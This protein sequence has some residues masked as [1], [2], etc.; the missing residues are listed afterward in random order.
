MRVICNTQS[1]FQKVYVRR[2]GSN[3]RI[4]KFFFRLMFNGEDVTAR[5]KFCAN[6][7]IIVLSEGTLCTFESL[8][9]FLHDDYFSIF[10]SVNFKEACTNA[11]N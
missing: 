4:K 11:R 10:N 2:E 9:R 1:L 3:I 8:I 6:S 7:N 5:I